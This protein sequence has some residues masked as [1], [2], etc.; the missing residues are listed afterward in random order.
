MDRIRNRSLEKIPE[1]FAINAGTIEEERIYLLNKL[2]DKEVEK[3]IV[4][5]FNKKYNK[6][7][8]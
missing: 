8:I 3:I 2:D 5:F 4:T 6:Q 7:N 1:V